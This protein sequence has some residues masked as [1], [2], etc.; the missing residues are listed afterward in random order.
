[1]SKVTTTREGF[2][3]RLK[4]ASTP[5]L[6]S[7]VQPKTYAVQPEDFIGFS[8]PKVL[9]E[10]GD[11]VQAGTPLFFSKLMPSVQ[12][13]SP[14]SGEIAAIE[15]GPKRKL[16]RVV[17][18]ADTNLS[19]KIGY[20]D[21]PT[22]THEQVNKTDRGDLI[23]NIC[24]SGVWPQLIRRPYGV[25]ADPSEE[26]SA[27]FISA[28]DTSPLAP[29]YPYVFEQDRDA[30]VMGITVLRKLC[31]QEVHI[32]LVQGYPVGFVGELESVC[33]HKFSG[34]HPVGNVG[35]QLHHT[36]PIKGPD[37]L[38]WTISLYGVVEL[39][40]LFLDGKYN[41]LHRVPV[42]GPLVENPTYV[43]VHKGACISTLVE[44]TEDAVLPR[45]ISGNVLTGTR[46]PLDGHLGYYHYQL[47]VIKEGNYQEPFGWV[48]PSFSKLSVQRG[49]G[50]FSF[51]SRG[52]KYAL[53][54]NLHGELRAFVQTGLFERLLPMD[55]LLSFLL[56]AILAEDFEE[57]EALGIYE[58]VEEDV[59]LCEFADVS[60]NEIQRLVRQGIELLRND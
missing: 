57:M 52:S 51:L 15:R 55:I 22:Y 8:R 1:M 9:V 40:R 27:I 13:T 56:K 48:L 45:Y 42:Q 37:D 20:V 58:L 11:E 6:Q 38:V 53:D 54:S 21:F 44:E 17:V 25:V 29:T 19:D 12:Y 14:V 5:R 2:T 50:L 60:K 26:P 32:G 24:L 36:R 10:V 3:I 41:T 46:V 59:A 31:R 28:A 4:G 49:L 43:A 7:G 16:L 34:P 47:T 39:G 35:V 30:F 23:E 33:Y 18:L